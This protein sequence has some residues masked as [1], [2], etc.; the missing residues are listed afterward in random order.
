MALYGGFRKGE[1]LA[2]SWDDIDADKHSISITKS[3]TSVGG[4]RIVKMPKNKKSI[5]TVYLPDIC[6]SL[7]EDWH[8]QQKYLQLSHGSKWIGNKENLIFINEL[9][10]LPMGEYVPTNAFTSI[11]KRYNKTHDNY[12]RFGDKHTAQN[13]T[14]TL[15]FW[16]IMKQT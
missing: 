1:L 3:A 15:L 8:I 16:Y 11:I 5:R 6:F 2:L 4:R 14:K 10:G 12:N 9:N 7:L 13:M